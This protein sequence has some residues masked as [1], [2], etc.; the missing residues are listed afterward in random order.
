MPKQ[1]SI[2]ASK[3][4]PKVLDRPDGNWNEAIADA[5]KMIAHFKNR[6]AGLKGAIRHFRQMQEAGESFPG[7]DQQ[8][9]IAS[10]PGREASFLSFYQCLARPR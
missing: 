6:I 4:E 3:K 2:V 9:T 7:S 10:L 1:T 8:H 5:E